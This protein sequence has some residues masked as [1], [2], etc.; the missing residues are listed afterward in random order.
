MLSLPRFEPDQEIPKTRRIEG[1][2]DG[3]M[4]GQMGW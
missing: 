2:Q 4:D 3:Q 1:S